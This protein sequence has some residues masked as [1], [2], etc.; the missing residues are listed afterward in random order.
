MEVIGLQQKAS[1][2]GATVA[3]VTMGDPLTHVARSHLDARPATPLGGSPPSTPSRPQ[4]PP[5]PHLNPL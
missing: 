1:P 5:Q 2:R 4:H 3:S